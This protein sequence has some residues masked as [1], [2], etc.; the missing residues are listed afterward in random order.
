M[1]PIDYISGI[2]VV[3][4]DSITKNVRKRTHRKK[5]ID[6]KWEKRY[7]Y[8]SVI[9]DGK[10]A[11]FNGTIYMSQKCFEKVKSRLESEEHE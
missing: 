5:R 8:K 1:N 2:Q 11:M 3:I 6:K 9:D 7:G 10:C 4:T